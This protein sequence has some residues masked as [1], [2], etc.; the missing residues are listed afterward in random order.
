MIAIAPPRR[1]PIQRI[2][3]DGERDLSVLKVGCDRNSVHVIRHILSLVESPPPVDPQVQ[4]MTERC[5]RNEAAVFQV[6]AKLAVQPPS[7]ALESERNRF[8]VHVYHSME[9]RGVMIAEPILHI[10]D[11]ERDLARLTEDTDVVDTACVRRILEH[12]SALESGVSS[13]L[14]P[15]V[16]DLFA[17]P[18][19][20]QRFIQQHRPEFE[21]LA[22]VRVEGVHRSPR[23][24]A[25]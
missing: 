21:E 25:F 15:S 24:A 13:D 11:G 8:M 5:L 7:E 17:P 10:F 6:A 3:R 16:D 18:E 23:L 2:W 22:A 19:N 1:R 9:G 4:E 14:W 20:V 12:I